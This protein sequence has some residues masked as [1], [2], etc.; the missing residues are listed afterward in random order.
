MSTNEPLHDPADLLDELDAIMR[1]QELLQARTTALQA[2]Y[3]SL[4]NHADRY[5]KRTSLGVGYEEFGSV[6]IKSTVDRLGHAAREMKTP[7]VW[8]VMA[9]EDA[10]KLREYP[11]P[12]RDLFDRSQV[13]QGWS[14]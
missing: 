9:R 4:E 1:E 12:E 7:L 6:N 11:R 14:L 3:K 13:D 2:R 5:D 8:A 10:E